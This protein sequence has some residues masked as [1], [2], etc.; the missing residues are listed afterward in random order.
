MFALILRFTLDALLSCTPQEARLGA[1]LLTIAERQRRG[2]V[3]FDWRRASAVTGLWR[4]EI[5]RAVASMEQRR[6]VEAV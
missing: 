4:N 3:V 1:Y 2:H 5:R 6:W